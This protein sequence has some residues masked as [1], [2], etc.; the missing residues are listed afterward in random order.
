MSTFSGLHFLELNF[1]SAIDQ[2]QITPI[3]FD[4]IFPTMLDYARGLS[5]NPSLNQTT[6]NDVM[7][8]RDLELKRF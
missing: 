8:M 6:L 5:L 7:T 1:D 3:G 2:T 4:I